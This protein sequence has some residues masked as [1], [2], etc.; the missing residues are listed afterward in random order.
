MAKTTIQFNEAATGALD[1]LA[2]TLQASKAEIV[3]NSLSL[4]SF[5]LNELKEEGKALAVIK[6]GAVEARIAVPGLEMWRSEQQQ[7]QVE[8]RTRV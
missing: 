3:R 2:D 6:N 7:E 4:Y 5:V 1:R 8:A